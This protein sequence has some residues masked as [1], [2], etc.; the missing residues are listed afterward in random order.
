MRLTRASRLAAVVALAGA[1]AHNDVVDV[2]TRDGSNT[3]VA[4][5]LAPAAAGLPNGTRAVNRFIL[6][7][8]D[9]SA[10]DAF[11]RA[12]ANPATF[13]REPPNGPCYGTTPLIYEPGT[14]AAVATYVPPN[15][16]LPAIVTPVTIQDA[17]CGTATAYIVPGGHPGN[18]TG[19]TFWEFWH[20]FTG[21]VASTRYITGLVRYAV[22][23]RG[24]FDQSEI[25]QTG[26]V[27]TPDSLVFMA[28][29]FNPAGRKARDA[30]VACGSASIAQPVAG[31]NPMLLGSDTTRSGSVDID[32]TACDTNGVWFNGVGSPASPVPSN[33]L[34]MN[35]KQYNFFVI[36]VAKADSTPDYTK[37]VYRQQIG[38]LLT[39]T[40]QVINNSF[41]PVPAAALTS[42]QL[43]TRPG[44]VSRPDTMRLTF[45]VLEPLSTGAYQVFLLRSGTDTAQV[46]TGRVIRLNGATAVDTA[47]GV[48]GF[49]T[50]A[51]VTTGATVVIDM[52]PYAAINWSAATLAI[53]ASS[54]NTTLPA[55]Q[56]IWTTSVFKF[57]G[58][59][60]SLSGSLAFGSFNK[61]TSPVLFGA[62][63]SGTGGVFG[64]ELREDVV[65]LARP[66]VGYVYE[67]WLFNSS[68]ATKKYNIGSLLTP[69]PGLQSLDD[70]DTRQTAPLAGPEITQAAI[71]A[72]A[73]SATFYCDYDKVQVR[74]AP[75]QNAGAL[76][77][78]V[79]L[80]SGSSKGLGVTGCP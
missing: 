25:L 35:T 43:A 73:Q 78:A 5:N 9:T 40:G 58:Q 49:N 66:P 16:Y 53:G 20:D 67:A 68:D 47:N 54:G 57:A 41:A 7:S 19:N 28:G 80:S 26:T 60:A 31:A 52:A 17:G 2:I 3:I 22:Q 24:A 56:P 18:G 70:A 12:S 10:Y 30:F 33:D 13:V 64:T 75:R 50:V 32:M 51:G 6:S 59:S 1:C 37:P 29:D 79:I 71:R 14:A 8:F 55:S 76:P 62:A 63:G 72:V 46:V 15:R 21:A 36:W 39:T 65:R 44:G 74:L 45:N 23:A 38:P 34:S 11:G 77:A 61:G 48:T 4:I 42:T 27:T 69:Y